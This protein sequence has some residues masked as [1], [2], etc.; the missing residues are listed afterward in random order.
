[1]VPE[2]EN[3]GRLPPFAVRVGELVQLKVEPLVR[4]GSVTISPIRRQVSNR[5]P[6]SDLGR[7]R[8]ELEEAEVIQYKR[9]FFLGD[10]FELPEGIK[11]SLRH[12]VGFKLQLAGSLAL[13]P[14]EDAVVR[15]RPRCGPERVL[16]DLSHECPTGCGA[17]TLEISLDL[18]C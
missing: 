4:F 11:V 18:R 7:L 13:L 2:R 9:S 5:G 3:S 16:V 8:L 12:L 6:P 14:V 17:N 1:V 10:R 15:R